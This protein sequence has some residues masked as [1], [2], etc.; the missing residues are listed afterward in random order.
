MRDVQERYGWFLQMTGLPTAELEMNFE[1]KLQRTEMFGR[2]VEYGDSMY[3][4]LQVID[5]RQSG[6]LRTL[7]I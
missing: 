7:V 6:L 4:L 1:D 3:R 5:K 2:A